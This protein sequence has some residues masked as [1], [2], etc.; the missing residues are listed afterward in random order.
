[1]KKILAV[2]LAMLTLCSLAA[3]EAVKQEETAAPTEPPIPVGNQV[4]EKCYSFQVE[5]ADENGP[6][7]QWIDPTV[8]GKITVVN[9]WGTWC[10]PCVAELPHFEEIAGNYDV[11]IVAIHSVENN[12]DMPDFIK[13]RYPDSPLTFAY[14]EKA[15]SGY[16][17]KN[18]GLLGGQGYYPYTLVLDS[19][20]VIVHIQ[21]G[22]MS[23]EQLEEIIL[24]IR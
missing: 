4:G 7:G 3:C 12:R 6:T 21:D 11:E 16:M 1:M 10:N 19:E 18:Y 14:D 24:A 20:G 17:D 22:A 2:I 8:T 23:Y 13:E 9:F 15:E 5:L